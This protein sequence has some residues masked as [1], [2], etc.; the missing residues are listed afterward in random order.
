MSHPDD[1]V[2]SLARAYGLS[3]LLDDDDRR[4]REAVATQPE[5]L[6]DLALVDPYIQDGQF[7]GF[8]LRP[9]RDRRLLQQLGLRGG[10]VITEVNG[11]RLNDPATGFALLQEL[12]NANQ[13]TVQVLRNG[14]EIPF[15]FYANAR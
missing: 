12:V 15:T 3:E 1:L 9:G 5:T 11:T 10:D 7:L 13:F 4:F 6:Q 2:V 8:R 14:N